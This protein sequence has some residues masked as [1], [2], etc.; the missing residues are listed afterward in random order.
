MRTLDGVERELTPE[1]LVIADAQKAQA[2]AG[3][4]GGG[5]AEVS[6]GDDDDAAR[7]GELQPREHSRA[8]SSSAGPAHGGIDPVREGPASGAGGCTRPAGR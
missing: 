6:A 4:M 3:V 8:P 5:E 2:V 1:M 7:G